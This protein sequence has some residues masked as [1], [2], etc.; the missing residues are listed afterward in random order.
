MKIRWAGHAQFVIQTAG[1]TI[2]TDPPGASYGYPPVTE[3]ADIVTVSHEHG[4]HNAVETLTGTPTVL[5][6]AGE[7]VIDGIS[8]TGFPSWHDPEQGALRGPNMIYKIQSE[9]LNLVHLG[10]LGETLPEATLQALGPVDILMLPIGSVYTIDADAAYDLVQRI[11][12]KIVVP[13]HYMTPQLSFKL[14]PPEKFTQ[15]F[16]AVVYRPFLEISADDLP[17]ET[18]VMMLTL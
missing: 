3:A 16:D 4:D 17:A 8:L 13:M 5:K 14:D 6:T 15:K 9:G 2:I 7:T 18:Q 1:K 12:P 11:R 10:D